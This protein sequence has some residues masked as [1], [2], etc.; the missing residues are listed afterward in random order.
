MT[1]F[2]DASAAIPC[3]RASAVQWDRNRSSQG[4]SRGSAAAGMWKWLARRN[5]HRSDFAVRPGAGSGVETEGQTQPLFP[6]EHPPPT[7]PAS[8]TTGSAP[9]FFRYQAVA[10]PTTPPPTTPTRIG[11]R[12]AVGPSCGSPPDPRSKI[13]SELTT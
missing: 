11:R 1:A 10:S 8:T 9:S 12:L 2:S 6:R 13:A 5:I 7:P 4:A 3:A